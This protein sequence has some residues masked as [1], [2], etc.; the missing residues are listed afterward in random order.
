MRSD[1]ILACVTLG[2][3]AVLA[4]SCTQTVEATPVPPPAFADTTGEAKAEAIEYPAGPFGIGVGSVI[5]NYNFVGYADAATTTATMQALSLADFYNPHG[6]DPS[7]QPAAG[8]PDDRLFPADSGYENAGK[9]KPTVLL[10]DIAC[11]WCGPCNDEAGTIIP[12]KH[13]LYSACGGEFFLDLHDSLTPGTPATPTNLRNW[14]SMYKVS[15]PAALDPSFQLDKLFAAQAFPQN[16]IIDTT[17][18]K[19]AAVT[20]GEAVTGVCSD[21]QTLCGTP[22]DLALCADTTKYSCGLPTAC[23]SGACQQLPFWTTYESLLDKTRAGC[24]L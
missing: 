11:V 14:T 18:M 7:Y 4:A 23:P 2:T 6:R 17:T 10:I 22:A 9:A 3:L 13:D 20:A 19:I 12:M 16:M 24:T 5:A 21:D 1:A 15:F 8:E